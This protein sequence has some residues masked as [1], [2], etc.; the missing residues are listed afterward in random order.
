MLKDE[1]KQLLLS[2]IDIVELISQ[3]VDLKKSGSGYK[4]LSPFK[5]EKTPSFMVSPTKKIFKDFSSDIGGDA[6]RFYMLINK[7]SYLEAIEQLA[8]YNVNINLARSNANYYDKY[9]NLT[10]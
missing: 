8:K 3:Y 1:D 7:I 2:K 5:D 4:G 9:Y 6:I 10:I